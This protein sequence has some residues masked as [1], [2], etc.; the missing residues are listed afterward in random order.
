MRGDWTDEVRRAIRR[1]LNSWRG[2]ARLCV[3]VSVLV[4]ESKLMDWMLQR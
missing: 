2:T 4:V 1:G 3:V